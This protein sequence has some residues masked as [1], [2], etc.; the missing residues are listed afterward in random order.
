[1]SISQQ[2]ADWVLDR[3]RERRLLVWYDPDRAFHALFESLD[4][5]PLVKVDA[6]RSMLLARR[7]ADHA[8][9]AL[10]DTDSLGPPPPPI[11]IYVPTER[12]ATDEAKRADPFEPFALAGAVFGA[13]ADERLPSI[14]RQVLAG[15]EPQVDRLFAE[16]QPTLAQLDALAA[17]TRYPLLL[18]SLGTDIPARV[19]A[20]VLCRSDTV[21]A[22]AQSVPGLPADLQ[23]LL[24]DCFGF[25]RG[26]L[27]QFTE[28]GPAFAQWL[29]FSEFVFDLPGT[30][31]ASVSRVPR[32]EQRLKRAIYDLCQD[33][34]TS[35]EYRDAYR[36]LAAEVERR[37]GLSH[38]GETTDVFGERDT[39]PFED[40]A[41]LRRL[42]N[43][44]LAGEVVT[45]RGIA[46]QRRSS[47]WRSQPERD[48]L[49]RLA[50]RCL[51]LLEAGAAWEVRQVGAD[52]PVADHVRAYCAEADGLW[53]LD[54]AQRLLEQAAAL[55]V[56]R[57]S[58]APLL[59]R[60]RLDYRRWLGKAQDAFLTS[61]TRSGW[62]AE[63]F[64]RQTQ[65]WARHAAGPV[66]EGRRTAWLMVDALRFEMGKEL[67]ARLRV[68]GT[69]RVE[70]TCGVVPAATPFGMAA[71]LPGAELGLDY[72][73]LEGELV[74]LIGGR[75]VVTA[76]DRRAVFRAALGDR[77][78]DLRLGDLL[79]VSTAAL[80]RR[81]GGADVLAV[82]STEIDDFGEH[83][84]PLLARRYIGEVVADLLAAANRLVQLGFTRLVFVADHGFIQLPEVL[85]GDRCPEPAGRWLL[86]KRRALLGALGARGDQVVTIGAATLGLDPASVEQV[87]VP[88]GIKVFRAGSP[89]FHEGLSLQECLVPVV[90]LDAV[91]RQPVG[92][93]QAQVTIAYRSDRFT[94]RI[95][96]VQ[97]GYASLL[98]PE[99]AVRL[100]ACE[101]GTSRVVGEA[102]DCEARDPHTG[103]VT[104]KANGQV[105]VPIAL[106][107]DFD[108]ESVE[109]RASAANEPG[110]SFASLVLRNAILD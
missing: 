97:V 34:R 69:V 47:V 51:D 1:M 67:A 79:T 84:D 24:M 88:R 72:G 105:Q 19:A 60:G 95:F 74:P 87:C 54:Q 93:P 106:A 109:V 90:I 7:E 38:L 56:D 107:P 61:V 77:F 98:E 31:P 45:A 82:F 48:Q 100:Q 64:A 102:A 12:G 22:A 86:C 8:W 17:G 65:V 55:L 52:R 26:G 66:T 30:V 99:L 110:R 25:D 36:E 78:R 108:G 76:E 16:G 32:A 101:P 27:V 58:L 96:S 49:W 21:A 68:E 4:H 91:A 53:R 14:A 29:L 6:S 10:F 20:L 63:G 37:L 35:S 42:Q 11:L 2:I 46:V 44:A 80:R 71:L 23:R 83:T 92:E 15:Q 13:S 41:A 70:P 3:L 18:D 94:T 5:R 39:F 81:V 62:P 104:L 28:M 85:P 50:E 40:H 43:A 75:P 33:L 73:E 103:L 57:D 9:R 59:E 89:Y